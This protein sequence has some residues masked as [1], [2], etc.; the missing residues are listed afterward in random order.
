MPEDGQ[1]S[2]KKPYTTPTL[3]TYGDVLKLTEAV[4]ATGR[5]DHVFGLR[6]A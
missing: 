3:V 4:G 2:P 1:Q 6:T 5:T